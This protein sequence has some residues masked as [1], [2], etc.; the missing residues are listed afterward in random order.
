EAS[1]IGLGTWVMGGWMW[2]G[3]EDRESLSTLRRAL[4]L[5]VNL[6]DTAPIYGHGRSEELVGRAIAES[7]RRDQVLLATKV[8]LD[9]DPARKRV[10]RNSSRSRILQE[11]DDS[12]RRLQVDSID[13][14]Q[15][16]WPDAGTAFEETME[17][18]LELQRLQKIRLIGLSNFSIEQIARCRAVGPVHVLQ[19]PFNLLE[20]EIEREMLPYCR[21]Q[22]IATLIYG[23][24]CRGLLSGK[25]RG[26]ETF[27]KGD[28]RRADP[29]FA[30]ERFP[31]YLACVERLKVVA[32][33]LGKTIGQL[34]IR[35]CLDQPGV[36]VALC[37][38]RRPDHVDEH[39]GA[40]GWTLSHS[41]LEEIDRIVAETIAAPVGPQFMAPPV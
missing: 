26:G 15:V 27:A 29:K 14:Y 20:R 18:L 10:W 2:G 34:A 5:G 8:G 6:I 25:Y 40:I 9:W 31:A 3:A 30:A 36:T 4:D 21:E 35:W 33:R 32:G 17:A 12:L 22:H 16:H 39:V 41:D 37:G 11:I 24:L 13:I 1:V 23:P 7:G 19:P 38:A 28:L